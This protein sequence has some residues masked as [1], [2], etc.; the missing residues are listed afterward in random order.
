MALLKNIDL[1]LY[2][3]TYIDKVR[4]I[5]YVYNKNMQRYINTLS[6]HVEYRSTCKHGALQLTLTSD[7]FYGTYWKIYSQN[8][9]WFKC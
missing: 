6:V 1:F 7:D 2:T 3:N 8:L 9:E 4:F 5:C